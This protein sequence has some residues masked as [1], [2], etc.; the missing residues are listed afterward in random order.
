MAAFLQWLPRGFTGQVSR[1]TDAAVY[2]V[3][4]GRGRTSVGGTELHWGPRDVFVTPS[5][6]PVRHFA[7]DDAILFSLSDRPAQEALG[8]WREAEAA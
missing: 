7:D 3:V 2:C 6:S 5:W 4:E 1:S 8:L